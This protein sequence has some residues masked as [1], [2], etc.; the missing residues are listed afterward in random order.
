MMMQKKNGRNDMT[1][2]FL[3]F[4][5]SIVMVTTVVVEFQMHF[6]NKKYQDKQE[7]KKLKKAFD[8]HSNSNSKGNK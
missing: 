7:Q 3:I 5:V 6:R 1:A 4:C 8:F 2:L